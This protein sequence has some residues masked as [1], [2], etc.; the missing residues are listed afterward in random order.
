MIQKQKISADIVVIVSLFV[1]PPRRYQYGAWVLKAKKRNFR[2][3][4]EF[5][6]CRSGS[7][8]HFGL[9]KVSR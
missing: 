9:L 5:V 2:Y 7:F 4:Y 1:I 8:M 6:H 3:K